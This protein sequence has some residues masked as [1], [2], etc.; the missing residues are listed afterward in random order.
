MEQQTSAGPAGLAL[1][2]V[3]GLLMGT[4]DIIPGGSGGT[5]ALIVGIYERLIR[6]IRNIAAAPV[7][8]VRG[9]VGG[10]RQRLRMVEW[11]LILPLAA[12]ILTALILGA[13]VVERLLEAYP[14]KSRA[15]FF[16]LIAASLPLPWRRVSR[17]GTRA[18]VIAAVF[19]VF[20]FIV[21]SLPPQTITDPSLVLVF[22]SASIA[23]CA[24][25][26]PG[27]SG[28]FLLVIFGMYAPTLGAVSDRDI[29]YI[30]VFAAGA[31]IGLGLFSQLLEWLLANRHDATMAALVGLMVGSLRVL[32]PWQDD[33]RGFLAPPDG[34]SVVPVLLLALLGFAIVTALVR[35]AAAKEPE[36]EPERI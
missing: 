31:I 4:A 24:M 20:A 25:I 6:S 32:W 26:L 19:A 36:L 33:D 18:V 14:A 5:V 23:I 28:A 9:D 8:L 11:R 34:A 13:L 1:N 27:L 22:V 30:L 15:L 16:G 35:L 7:A 29:A 2:F 21:T 3:R 17:P 12:G 10:M